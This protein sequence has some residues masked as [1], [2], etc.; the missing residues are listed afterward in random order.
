MLSTFLLLLLFFQIDKTNRCV[1]LCWDVPESTHTL[2]VEHL[3]GVEF[4]SLRVNVLS[5]Y[6]KFF[7]SLVRHSSKEVAL[8]ANL[9]G[10]DIESTTGRN[11]RCI[12]TDTGLNPWRDT[13]SQIKNEYESRI[14]LDERDSWKIHLLKN[15]LARRQFLKEQFKPTDEIDDLVD[16]LCST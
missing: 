8:I 10:R 6:V 7:Q 14:V 3:L 1:K 13:S 16:S 15:Y 2:F 5:R 9:V 4:T 12:S 11:L